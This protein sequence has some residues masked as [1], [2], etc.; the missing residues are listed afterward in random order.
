MWQHTSATTHGDE[1]A[2]YLPPK[3]IAH[4]ANWETTG[5]TAQNVRCCIGYQG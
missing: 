4:E 2:I 5:T 1:I 3:A